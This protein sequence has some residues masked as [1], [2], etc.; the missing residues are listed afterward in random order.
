MELVA[1]YSFRLKSVRGSAGASPSLGLVALYSFRL[2]SVR[3]SAGASPSMELV[4]LYGFRLNLVHGSAGGLAL[5]GVGGS[6]WIPS[7]IGA[8]LGGSLEMGRLNVG[9]DFFSELSQLV[10]RCEVQRQ[11]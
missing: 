2:K 9:Q 8:R 3:G 7:E 11:H 4:A 10:R 6:P 5:H 1:L